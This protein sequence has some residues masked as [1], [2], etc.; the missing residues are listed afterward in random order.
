[1]IRWSHQEARLKGSRAKT[2][3]SLGRH[4]VWLIEVAFHESKQHLGFEEP[5]GWTRRAVERTAPLG[6]LLYTLIVLWFVESG[7]GVYRP[8]CRPWYVSKASVSFGDML[9]TLRRQSVRQKIFS[10]GL[11]GPGSRKIREILENWVAIAA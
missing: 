6:M 3:P 5:P 10:L 2:Q 1:M 11:G 4:Y 7:H 9:A 8:L